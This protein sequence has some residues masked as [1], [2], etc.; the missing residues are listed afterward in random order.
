MARLEPQG[1]VL[2]V[3]GNE[4]MPQ[5]IHADVDIRSTGLRVDG[6]CQ[7]L[8]NLPGDFERP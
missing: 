1:V 4:E 7:V 6:R 5:H 8:V 2:E 3:G